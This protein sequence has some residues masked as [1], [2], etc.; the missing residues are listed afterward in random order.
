MKAM[1]ISVGGAPEPVTASVLEHKPEYVCFFVSQQSMALLGEIRRLI[2]EKGHEITD[3]AVICDNADNILCCYEKALECT[4]K[5]AEQGAEPENV[6]VDYTGGTKTMTAALTLATF[7]QGYNF[8]CAGGENRTKNGAGVSGEELVMKDIS[9]WQIVAVEE[10]KR[11]SLFISS[12]IAQSEQ[13][14]AKARIEE[15]N[16]VIADLSHHI[17]NIISSTVVDPLEILR[18]DAVEP[19][20]IQNALKGANLVNNIVTAMNLSY[21]G[22]VDDFYY[23]AGCN[24]GQEKNIKSVITDSLKHSVSNIYAGGY[25]KK[26]LDKYF[27][28]DEIYRKSKSE[29]ANVSQADNFDIIKAFLQEYFFETD[30]F[31][32][33]AE[34]YVIGNERYSADKLLILFQE[35][36]MNA[37]K[38]AS[39]VKKEN[40]FLHVQLADNLNQLSVKVENSFKSD[41][42]PRSSGIGHVIIKNFA[43]ILGTKPII[44]KDNN[45][46]STEIR[47]NNFWKG[48][49]DEN[50]V[51]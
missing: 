23:D 48:K 36:I 34:K 14:K 39:Y 33:E 51:C 29:W 41:L 5:L 31:F 20:V 30:I 25:F 37:V 6:A 1:I 21:K 24:G 32:G 16:K 40:R 45:V 46:Y 27:P 49:K 9:P 28:T 22:S 11:K 13:E 44:S 17:I 10:K 47:F 42:R 38:Y 2:S 50:T 18:R 4:D 8:S 43:D 15:R 7:G 3:D 26:Y 19:H 12:Y 35:L